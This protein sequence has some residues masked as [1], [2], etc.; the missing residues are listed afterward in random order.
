VSEDLSLVCRRADL[1]R[2]RMAGEVDEEEAVPRPNKAVLQ[3]FLNEVRG[4]GTIVR[5]RRDPTAG[6]SIGSGRTVT[7]E[8]SRSSYGRVS[9]CE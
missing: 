7:R 1:A 2:A 4:S 8:R 6:S 9:L 3:R 5:G